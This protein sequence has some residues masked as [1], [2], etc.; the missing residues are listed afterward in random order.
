MG[1]VKMVLANK[2]N[3]QALDEWEDFLEQI[4]NSTPVDLSETP[5]AKAKRMRELEAPGNQE[6]WIAYYFP[7]F[8]FS[9]PAKFQQDS[10]RRI[11]NAIRK[12]GRMYQ[13][14]AWARGLAKSTR[15]MMEIF[16][17]GFVLDFPINLLLCSKSEAN[18]IRLLEPYRGVLEANQRLIADYGTQ[19]KPGKWKEHEF[20]TRSGMSFRAVGAG[21]NPRGARNNAM[22]VTV[23]IFDD[24]DDD[25][26]CLNDERLNYRWSWIQDAVIPTIDIAKPY[27]IFFDNNI[28]SADSIAVRAAQY[29]DDVELVN[30][31]D[32]NGQSVWPEKNSEE[33]IDSILSKISYESGQKEYFNNPMTTG[34]AFPEMTWGKCP[35]LKSLQFAVIYADPST[36]NKDRPSV[37]SRATA[38]TKAVFLIG[39]HNNR[40]YVYN[41]FVDQT[42]ND[43]FVD[44]LFAL[45]DYVNGQCQV[46]AYIENNTLQDPFYQQVLRPLILERMKTRGLINISPDT[47]KKPDKWVRIEGT[48]EPLNRNGLLILNAAEREN[49]HMK[50]L[51]AQ[52]KGASAQSTVMD[53]PDAIEGGVTIIN[54][55]YVS[56]APNAIKA[57]TAK[58][59]SKRF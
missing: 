21:M 59:T 52:F 27:L 1:T 31:R 43:K 23:I 49:P 11:I 36:S 42:T 38:S 41:G 8:A 7:K 10:T 39:K 3:K 32:A 44:W 55:R 15:R 2:S 58:Q 56:M 48:L 4:R 47:R 57:Y 26:V 35:P 29:A 30:I 33:D 50:R 20:I 25:E 18:A 40:Y 22:R 5:A 19:E 6:K 14:R 53:G 13:R 28:I 45:R 37:R 24:I 16:Y 34:N 54:Q 12:T 17:V 51:E 46:F 9:K